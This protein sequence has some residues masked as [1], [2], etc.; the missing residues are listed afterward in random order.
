MNITS[1]QAVAGA[2]KKIVPAVVSLAV[3]VT[4]LPLAVILH[5]NG[6]LYAA[7]L[8]G[9]G[10]CD[11]QIHYRGFA[12]MDSCVSMGGCRFSHQD[13]ALVSAAGPLAD[14]IAMT[15]ALYL[16]KSKYTPVALSPQLLH[17]AFI[18]LA[19]LA[20]LSTDYTRILSKGGELAYAAAL[21][22]S[23]V[24]FALSWRLYQNQ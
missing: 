19:P 13:D 23:S 6:H 11:P 10:E 2:A 16:F 7:R 15:A 4:A 20:G 12:L 1:L 14:V 17:T 3:G 24:P 18:A 21:G 9:N 8:L 22:I 5:E